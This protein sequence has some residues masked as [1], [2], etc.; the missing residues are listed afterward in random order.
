[1]TS[2]TTAQA[3]SHE[4]GRRSLGREVSTSGQATARNRG[5]I[6]A[7]AALLAAGAVLAVLVYGNLGDRSP[8]LVVAREVSPGEVIEP[9]DVKVVR[10]SVDR[11][12][13]TIAASR[14]SEIVGQRA[15]VGLQPGM[16][17]S[18]ASVTDGPAMPSGST[19]IGAVV[20]PGQYPLGLHEGDEVIVL[21][22]GETT[23]RSDGG[24]HALIVSVSSR[25]GPE[26]TAISLAV[27]AGE[28]APLARAGAESGI[29]LTKPVR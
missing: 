17:L 13:A 7:G 23:D 26:G 10:V 25:S 5:R 21:L 22:A 15:A 18:T 11:E 2:T 19:V 20:K 14:R 28:A 24:V 6:A 3:P 16:L 9:G 29:L 1:M 8:V 12:V 4:N 27:P